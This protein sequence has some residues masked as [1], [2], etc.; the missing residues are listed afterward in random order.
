MLGKMS[1]NSQSQIT[2]VGSDHLREILIQFTPDAGARDYAAATSRIGGTVVETIRTA[3]MQAAGSGDLVRVTLGDGLSLD[4]AINIASKLEGVVFAEPNY[5]L[6]TQAVD[7][8]SVSNDIHYQDGKLWGMYGDAG[9]RLTNQYGS[10]ANEAWSKGHTGSAKTAVGV[11][12]TGIDYTHPDLF[13]N[14][15]INQAEIPDKIWDTLHDHDGDGIFTFH[16]LNHDAEKVNGKL[17]FD[18]NGSGQVDG[19]DLI[20]STAKRTPWEDG[21]DSSIDVNGY[22]DDLI[23]WNFVRN[24][25]DPYDDNDHGTH[26]SGTIGGTGNNGAGVAGVNWS[27]QLV[28]LK[29]LGA[30]GSGSLSNALKAIDYFTDASRD[31]SRSDAVL[32]YVATNN[33]WGGGG[34]S[35]A[36]LDAIARGAVGKDKV[37]KTHDDILFVAAA[38]NDGSDNDVNKRYPSGYDTTNVVVDGTTVGYDA[39]ISVASTDNLGKLSYFS[40]YGDTTVDLGAPGSDIWSIVPKGGYKAFSGT[41]M[42]TPHVTGAI[43]LYAAYHNK[44]S[45]SDATISRKAA[46]EIK[47]ALRDSVSNG[48]DGN[49]KLDGLTAWDGRLDI[50]KLSA[51]WDDWLVG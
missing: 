29:F 4:R 15:S 34:Y 1:A 22:V 7:T 48:V 2:G 51:N 41:S 17:R 31:A 44:K 24:T 27:T 33:S 12:D 39:V 36:L 5:Q 14:V 38:G 3:G 9:S 32:D 42:A 8:D 20:A 11:I 43:A 13:K 50:G 49:T 46:M 19:R 40:N 35:E 10:Q 30:S 6:S 18:Y 37:G 16:D 47:D 25:N 21:I 26:V 23:G 28:P 45:E